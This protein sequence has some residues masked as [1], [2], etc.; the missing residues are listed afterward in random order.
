MQAYVG[1]RHGGFAMAFGAVALGCAVFWGGVI[2]LGDRALTALQQPA[3][4]ADYGN[5]GVLIAAPKGGPDKRLVQHVEPSLMSIVFSDRKVAQEFYD[6]A[7]SNGE[8]VCLADLGPQKPQFRG[9][10]W[11]LFSC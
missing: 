10:R 4:V 3:P 5:E 11:W 7:A 9:Q 1:R 6:E 2:Y 8:R